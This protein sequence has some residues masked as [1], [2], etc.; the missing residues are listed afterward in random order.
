MARRLPVSKSHATSPPPDQAQR[1]KAL[2]PT[3][4]ILVRAPAGSGKT[5]LLAERF[6][7]LLAE[8]EEPG[9]V[10]AITF[11][12]AAAAE[13]RNRILDEL[14]KDD[15]SPLAQRALEHSQRLGWNLLDLPAQL[16]IS[17]IDSFCRDL[18]LQ[19]PIISGLGGSLEIAE[20]PNELYRRAAR[21]TLD[22]VGDA[23]SPAGA[24][25]ETLLL[26]RDNNWKEMEELLV[27]M[28]GERD[29]WMHAFV[30]TGSQNWDELRERLEMS[31]ARAA[32]DASECGYSE[33][34]WDIVRACFT[35]LRRAAAYLRITFAEAG[36]VDFIEVAQIALSVL[37]DEDNQPTEAALA[38]ADR[39]RHLLVDEFQDTSR[40]QHELLGRLIAAWPQPEGRTCFVVGDP[41][42]SIYFFRGADA[43]LF[44][45]VE[46]IGLD[47]PNEPALRF[48]SVHLTANFRT[49]PP[50]V[51]RLNEIFAQV[52]AVDDGSG[53][54]FAQALPARETSA[55][56]GPHPVVD[57]PPGMWLH[58]EF[59]PQGLR[60]NARGY[61]RERKAETQAQRDAA[62]D[63]QKQEILALIRGHLP[64]MEKAR[65]AGDKYRIAVLGR[66]RKALVSVAQ[67][68]REAQI[69]FRAIELEPL[70]DRPEIID[71]LALAR[72]LLHRE[73][74]VAWLGVL[75]APWCGLSL[76]DLH[77]LTSADDEQLK[78]RP[79]PELLAERT[80]LLSQEGRAAA[81]RV[82][83]AIQYSERLRSTQ[84]TATPGTWLE[85][86]WLRLGGARCVDAAARANLDLLWRCLDD[87]PQ[88][89]QDFLGPALDA[90]LA[91]LN[92]LPDPAASSDCGVQLM[93]IHK[94]K[95][96]EF[97]VV[98]V[99]DLQAN[100]GRGGRK[101]LSWLERGLA[102]EADAID[103]D[104]AGA[105]TEFLVAPLQ[106]KGAESG[107]AKSLVDKARRER[108]SQETR[109][110][111]YVAATRAREELH[112]FARPEFKTADNQSLALVPPTGS[113]L[114]T[115]WPGLR[116][117]V[118]H[119]FAE[120]CADRSAQAAQTGESQTID[121]LAASAEN[122]LAMPA[123][124]DALAPTPTPL[125]RLPPSD[126]PACAELPSAAEEPLAGVGRLYERHEG[127]LI[128]R[129][130]GKAVHELF[131]HLAQL[132]AMDTTEV[133]RQSLALMQPRIAA[134]LRAFGIEAGHADRIAAQALEMVLR[135]ADDPQA[136]WILAA[137]AD[138][139][140]EARWTGVVSGGVRTVQV[141]RVFRAGPTPQYTG[142]NSTWW[143]VDYKTAHEDGLDPKAALPALRRMFAPQIEA[144][145]KVLR[146]L[147]GAEAAV[148][149]GLYYPRMALFDWW[150]L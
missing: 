121:S 27:N 108:E 100:A 34:E 30:L 79:V 105:I 136:Q 118:E 62:L 94:S 131:Q 97:E 32:T 80:Q 25:A 5:T 87:L 1:D 63:K 60:A 128:S 57:S 44:P 116:E 141:D 43:E 26:W 67:A 101:L 46:N 96:L 17:T 65:A 84:P 149:G 115:A 92:A 83:R 114:A 74:R 106:P 93:T 3:R 70:Q 9:Q 142:D 13:M 144:Y 73:N 28:L 18:A 66:T 50:L 21:R 138:A 75:R 123:P 89:E 16:R 132:L 90:A 88:G 130:L 38:V 125:R 102:P 137:H 8:V 15:P 119:S 69:P 147:H 45:R 127:G 135:A 85:Q 19:Q 139:A 49:T 72:A 145:A 99:P 148:R 122:V 2:D 58:L 117:E 40:R 7:R 53:I 98:I 10:V 48:D 35:L 51:E 59:I 126:Q 95:G 133:A 81:E 33:K 24:A 39:I 124:P 14:R 113:L 112:L 22:E 4:S 20:Q 52:F 6:L 11:T 82:L 78:F 104:S 134:N 55:P 12:N 150:E 91:K 129:A 61:T 111:L 76:A 23:A 103:E 140:S 71:A 47:I 29:H 42:Q 54:E 77:T 143:I 64:R 41:M 86:V 107:S 68:L 36:V 31:L 120:W 56:P 146:N 37:R 109:R 110:L